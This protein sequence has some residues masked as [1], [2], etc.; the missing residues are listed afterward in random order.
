MLMKLGN[1]VEFCLWL[2]LGEKG[3][4]FFSLFYQPLII[5][6]IAELLFPFISRVSSDIDNNN[7]NNNIIVVVVTIAVLVIT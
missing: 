1:F 7:Y 5:H 4:I 3:L 2:L 6:F